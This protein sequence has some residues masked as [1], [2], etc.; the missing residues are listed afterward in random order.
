[1]GPWRLELLRLVR[2][3]RVI[4][5]AATFLILGLSMP[6]L[7]YYLPQ[8]VK[9]AAGNGVMILAPK[10][11][12]ADAIQGFASN[13]GQLGTLVVAITAAAT[14]CVDAHPSLAAF[15][16]TRLHHPSQLLGPRYLTITAA[17]IAALALGAFGALYETVI[18]LGPVSVSKLLAGIALAALW[19]VFVTI[20]VA[21]LSTAMRGVA[22]VA[23]AAI[24]L[25]LGI[26]L[27][28]NIPAL[29]SWLPTRLAEGTAMLIMHDKA[30]DAWRPILITTAAS[31]ALV[32]VAL[33]RISR[34][35]PGR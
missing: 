22:A 31:F 8:L 1:M 12:S 27:L 26:A 16:R 20:L 21:A 11:T 30:N 18:L 3:R 15:Y 10:Q 33:G 2:T 25:L 5:L 17:S 28:A 13:S 35:E 34:R 24:A 9:H 4:V 6:I 14:L 32:G 7:T 19:I 29:S 23:G